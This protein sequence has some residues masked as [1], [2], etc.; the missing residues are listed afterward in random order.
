MKA[1][2]FEIW[3]AD[4]NPTI[5]TETGKV[6]PVIIIQTDLLNKH[7]PSSIICPIT[8][9]IRK[10]SEILRVHLKNG[11]FG[12]ED[13]CD[14]MIDQVRAIDKNRLIKKVSNIPSDLVNKVKS[15]LKIMFDIE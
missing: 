14:I 8:T 7:H 2:Q 12:L 11:C 5:G 4:L 1:K 15:N 3:L 9:N 13:P 10:E 6:R